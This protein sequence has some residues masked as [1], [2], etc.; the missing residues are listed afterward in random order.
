MKSRLL[1]AVLTLIATTTPGIADLQGS[2]KGKLPLKSISVLSFGPDGLLLIGDGQGTQILAVDTGD[3]KQQKLDFAQIEDIDTQLAGRLGT[4][5]KGIEILDLAVNPASGRIYFGI[6]KQDSKQYLILTLSGKGDIQDFDLENVTYAQLKLPETNVQIS[7][8]TDVAWAGDRVLAAARANEAF[9]SKIFVVPAPLKHGAT[10]SI[11]SA[12]TY[13]VQHQRWETKAPMSAIIPYTENDK[14]YI[15]GAFSCTPVVKYPVDAIGPGT[16][17]KGVSVLELGSGNRP[18]DMF[19]YEKGGKAYVLANTFRFHHE[20][21]PFGPSPYWTCRFERDLL[22]ETV[23]VNEKALR[24][25]GS[26]GPATERIQMIESFSGVTQMDK[27]DEGRAVVL[28]LA[29]AKLNLEV[30]N[31]P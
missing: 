12:E 25:L 27:I 2:A 16:K 20:K 29:E 15:V 4:T 17:V 23:D 26:E 11:Y 14:K 3:T 10:A 9:A 31:L 24:R 22:S 21:N 28:R 6:R 7:V 13:H 5:P 1:I 19:T 30:V 8:I 18:L